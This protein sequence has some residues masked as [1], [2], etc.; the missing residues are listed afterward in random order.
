GHEEYFAS[1]LLGD[2]LEKEGFRVERGLLGLSTAFLA[3]Y[4]TGKP[5]ATVAF[6][7]EY[8]ALEGLGHACGHHL[9]G[10]MSAAA[11]IGLKSAMDELGGVIRVYGTP[12]EETNGA[13][14][15]MAEAGLFDDCDIALMAHPYHSFER[16]GQSL[17]LDAIRF[18]FT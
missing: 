18:E 8:D 4:D 13:K 17:A 2:V 3:S 14:V 16:S 5:G 15:P 6:L 9:I 10:T 1:G 12:A 7:A 11:A